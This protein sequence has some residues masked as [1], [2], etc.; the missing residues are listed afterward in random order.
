MSA[1]VLRSS[2]LA[3]GIIAAALCASGCGVTLDVAYLISNKQYN[4][5]AEERRPTGQVSTAIEYDAA[6]SPDGQAR[7]SC[8][9]R[10]RT[11][12]RTWTVEKTF[13][14]RGGFDSSTYVGTA[15]ISALSPP[16]GV[17]A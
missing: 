12:D 1:P 13:Q 14:R 6:V 5:T 17:T 11:I 10:E 3:A 8:E 4:E 16:R 7:L 2:A 9:Q 15:S